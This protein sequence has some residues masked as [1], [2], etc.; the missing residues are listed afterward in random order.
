ML[1]KNPFLESH[2]MLWCYLTFGYKLSFCA[3]VGG[4]WKWKK[5]SVVCCWN[6]CEVSSTLIGD[7]PI[8]DHQERELV[9]SLFFVLSW[10]WDHS[11]YHRNEFQCKHLCF[12][13]QGI[14]CNFGVYFSPKLWQ[15]WGIHEAFFGVTFFGIPNLL[16]MTLAFKCFISFFLNTEAYMNSF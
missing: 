14:F 9:L 8:S 5:G 1:S 16:L 2:Y 7:F 15:S 6:G 3:W 11:C 13:S 4:F 10:L 12:I